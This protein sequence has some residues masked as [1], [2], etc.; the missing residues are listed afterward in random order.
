MTGLGLLLVAP[1]VLY[2]TTGYWFTTEAL[3]W[4]TP[5]EQLFHPDVLAQY[6]PWLPAIAGPLQAAFWEEA[7][8]RA[9]PIAGA[10]LLGQRFGGTRYWRSEERRVGTER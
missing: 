1:F 2:V 3:G 4:W 9:I 6:Q 8:F 10:V 7:M 5:S